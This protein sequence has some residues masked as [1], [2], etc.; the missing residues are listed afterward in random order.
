MQV[1]RYRIPG[2]GCWLLDAGK[3]EMGEGEVWP[4]ARRSLRPGGKVELGMGKSE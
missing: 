2:A 4:P 3:I 1:A